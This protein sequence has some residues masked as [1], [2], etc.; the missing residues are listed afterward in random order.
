MG[1][2]ELR[3]ERLFKTL[4]ANLSAIQDE[5]E[6]I[7]SRLKT[8]ERNGDLEASTWRDLRLATV[9]SQLARVLFVLEEMESALELDEGTLGDI[10]QTTHNVQG[11]L[12]ELRDVAE[13]V[14]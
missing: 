5:L 1:T 2:D 10:E 8:R 11:L 14:A 7:S 3:A 12:P 13:A 6:L 4:V 9:T